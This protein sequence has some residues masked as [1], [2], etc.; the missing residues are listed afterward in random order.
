MQSMSENPSIFFIFDLDDTL[1]AERDYVRSAL[2]WAGARIA[3]I[4]NIDDPYKTLW[5]FFCAGI[6]N[7]LSA[8]WSQYGLPP[9]C[10]PPLIAEMR[11]HSPTIN[12][13]D[14]A[15]TV[16][17]RLQAADHCFAIVTDGRS[18]TQRAKLKAL[19]INDAA[20]VSISEEAGFTKTDPRRFEP[21]SALAGNRQIVCVGDNPSK[22]FLVANALG[23]RTVMRLHDGAGIHSQSLPDDTAYHPQ[24]IVTSLLEI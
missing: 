18:I 8:A 14:D 16:L 20:L 4:Y 17:G 1:Y 2:Q 22:D 9:E 15:A 13:F 3:S 19:G 23:W 12:P 7:P 11:A 10:L 21:V 24:Q 5:G 6:P